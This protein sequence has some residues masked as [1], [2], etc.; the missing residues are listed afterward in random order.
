MLPAAEA[1]RR[2]WARN[3]HD[4][5]LQG[6]G[7]LKLQLARLG[8]ATGWSAEVGQADGAWLVLDRPAG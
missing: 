4:G 7:A 6:L 3:L 1:E 2:R 5:T 8:R